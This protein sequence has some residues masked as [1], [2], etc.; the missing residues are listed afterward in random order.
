M[1][2]SQIAQKIFPPNYFTQGEGRAWVSYVA[3]MNNKNGI[4]YKEIFI[5]EATWDMFQ[6]SV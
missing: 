1:I 4:I 3:F 5:K 6:I 2:F